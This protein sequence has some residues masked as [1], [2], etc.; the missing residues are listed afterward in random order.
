MKIDALT[1][2]EIRLP[3][4]HFFET[5]F[6]RLTDRRILLVSLHGGLPTDRLI[7]EWWL[8]SRRVKNLLEGGA[9]PDFA[10][11]ECISVPA[12]IYQWKSSP[13]DRPKAL[14]VQ[15]RNRE[16]LL[17]AFSRGLAVLGFARDE[18]G[19]GSYLLGHW[20]ENWSYGA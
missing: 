6:G 5:S 13:L 4:V 20:D 19:N 16:L 7:A 17:D 2:R 3:L 1:L 15:T 9:R 10:A 8:R 12:E 18:Q 14:E 11:E